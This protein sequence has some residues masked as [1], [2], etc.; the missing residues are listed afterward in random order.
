MNNT[1][2]GLLFLMIIAFQSC[3]LGLSDKKDRGKVNCQFV[4]NEIE[5][6]SEY[7]K[8]QVRLVFETTHLELG[9]VSGCYE[10]KP[11]DFEKYELPKQ[12]ISAVGS[13]LAGAGDYFYAALENDSVKVYK[14]WQDELQDDDGYHWELVFGISRHSL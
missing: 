11:E 4:C 10:I 2:F 6:D 9:E 8:H 7:Q 1:S 3:D 12:T 14:G 5:S 13:W